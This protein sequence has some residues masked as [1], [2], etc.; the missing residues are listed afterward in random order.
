M[1]A[2]IRRKIIKKFSE[3]HGGIDIV[4]IGQWLS[5]STWV[6]GTAAQLRRALACC[7]E[8]MM[9]RGYGCYR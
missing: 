6:P 2:R 7:L 5:Y 8:D 1:K 9:D 4:A 3:Q